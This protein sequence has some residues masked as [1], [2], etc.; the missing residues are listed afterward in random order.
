MR[1]INSRRTCRSRTRKSTPPSFEKS[2]ETG[3]ERWR[4]SGR[5]H[6]NH[7]RD[8]SAIAGIGMVALSKQD[9]AQIGCSPGHR[10]RRT[11][12]VAQRWRDDAR[13]YA[14]ALRHEVIEAHEDD[15]TGDVHSEERR[16]TERGSAATAYTE[17]R[18]GRSDTQPRRRA[19]S[20][21]GDAASRRPDLLHP[22][23][24]TVTA[25]AQSIDQF[26][27]RFSRITR[28]SRGASSATTT[29]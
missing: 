25:V 7:V 2:D 21:A 5:A 6:R 23:T 1:S 24:M 10:R 28:R 19:A 17:A 14:T 27:E 11:S 8:P 15:V 4:R 22:Q 26:R 3:A 16:K 18:A 13:H 29:S 12:F 9:S 20:C